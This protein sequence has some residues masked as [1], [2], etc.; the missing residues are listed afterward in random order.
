VKYENKYDEQYIRY[1]MS[2]LAEI[3][4][5]FSDLADEVADLVLPYLSPEEYFTFGEHKKLKEKIAG[6]TESLSGSLV[7][8]IGAAVAF[9]W[10]ISD[11]K[12]AALVKDVFEGDPKRIPEVYISPNETGLNRFLTRKVRGL[13]FSDR[14]WRYTDTLPS[15]LEQ[16]VNAA[17]EKGMSA[18]Q[19]SRDIRKYLK[20]PDALFRRVRDKNG[21]LVLSK[22]ALRYSPGQGV[23]RSAYKNAMR[24]A[25]TEINGAYRRADFERWQ[26]LPFVTGYRIRTTDRQFSTCDLCTELQ[27]IY[28]KDF[29]FAGWHPQ[30]LCVCTP[31]M[32]TEDQM[33]QMNRA[34]LSGAHPPEFGQPPLPDSFIQYLKEA[35]I[36]P[37]SPPDGYTDNEKFLKG[38]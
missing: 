36:N 3:D 10:G 34:I 22:S 26:H 4:G 1:L 19:L 5:L 11:R 18:A 31:V 30:C 32:I 8:R 23:Y 13:R 14:V 25:R 33:Q 15:E 12:N 6:E 21:R 17:M 24:L 27:G 2:M 38:K 28:P 16:A 37:D 35:K 29:C 9:A 20:N 7:T